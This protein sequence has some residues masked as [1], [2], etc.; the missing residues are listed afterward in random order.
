MS[1]TAQL[2]TYGLRLRALSVVGLGLLVV[3]CS[4][5]G[6][7]GVSG[8]PPPPTGGPPPPT[9]RAGSLQ[10]DAGS[11]RVNEAAGVASITITRTDG[12]DGDVSVAVASADGS[13]RAGQDYVALSTRVTFA[14]GDASAKTVSVTLTN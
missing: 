11:L 7:H 3:A 4:G 12:S 1:T 8:S 10:F 9:V 14:A 6:V 5:G 2:R 13:A